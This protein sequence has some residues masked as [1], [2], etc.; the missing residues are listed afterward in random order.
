MLCFISARS[1][2]FVQLSLTL[3]MSVAL[4]A[5]MWLLGPV[6]MLGL[7]VE[8][9]WMPQLLLRL[10]TMFAATSTSTLLMADSAAESS[11]VSLTSFRQLCLMKL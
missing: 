7:V 3:Y 11:R 1:F 9:A 4:L 2:T 8:L 5:Y 10:S 6:L